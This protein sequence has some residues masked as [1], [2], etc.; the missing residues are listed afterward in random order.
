MFFTLKKNFLFQLW[1]QWVQHGMDLP[2]H[3]FFGT[4]ERLNTETYISK[5]LPFY[6]DEGNR[7]FRNSNWCL[8]QDG[9]TA[10]TSARSQDWCKEYL[11]SF[12]PKDR[13]PF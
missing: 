9:A 4:G 2:F 11:N 7:F 10:H 5:L 8:Q 3:I 6:K 13:W 12:I 1:S